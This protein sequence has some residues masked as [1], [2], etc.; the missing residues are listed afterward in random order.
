MATTRTINGTGY[1]IPDQGDSFSNWGGDIS[2]WIGAVTNGGLFTQG[3]NFTLTNDVNFGPNYGLVSIYF[4]SRTAGIANTGV[5]QLANS[6][7][8]VWAGTG[9]QGDVSLTVD[10]NNYLVSNTGFNADSNKII[11]LATPTTGTDAVNKAYVDANVANL[12]TF[13]RYSAKKSPGLLR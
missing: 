6:D 12:E 3:G 5:L 13:Q 8:I 9:A 11:N 2:A 7:D 10:D 1:V 4:K